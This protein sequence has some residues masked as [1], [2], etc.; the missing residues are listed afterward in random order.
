M[1]D[2]QFT[3]NDETGSQHEG[4]KSFREQL[5]A[6]SHIVIGAAEGHVRDAIESVGWERRGLLRRLSRNA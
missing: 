2:A 6:T 3:R 5:D 1:H 4:Q